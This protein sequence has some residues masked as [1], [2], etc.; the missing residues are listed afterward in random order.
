VGV[1]VDSIVNVGRE[2]IASCINALKVG[3]HI[4][5]KSICEDGLIVVSV[6]PDFKD[7]CP[8]LVK[9]LGE[10]SGGVYFWVVRR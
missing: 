5:W 3:Q 1:I 4:C 6:C 7:V 10:E 2:A 9:E 8:Y